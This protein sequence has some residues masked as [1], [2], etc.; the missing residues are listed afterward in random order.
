MHVALLVS[1]LSHNWAPD[2]HLISH[3][4]FHPRS[5]SHPP[6]KAPSNASQLPNPKVVNRT[7]T[8]AKQIGAIS[9]PTLPNVLPSFA[10]PP[11]RFPSLSTPPNPE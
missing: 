9:F 8:R 11:L 2:F 7:K 3:F 4:F 5:L 10:Y 1:D 6:E